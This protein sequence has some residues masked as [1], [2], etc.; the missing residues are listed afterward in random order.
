[1]DSASLSSRSGG[2]AAAREG[3]DCAA[4]SRLAV[5]HDVAACGS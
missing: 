4:A 2:A 1:M 3:S 5:A